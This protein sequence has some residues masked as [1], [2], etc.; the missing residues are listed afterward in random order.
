MIIPFYII[1]FIITL[2]YYKKKTY[3][4]MLMTKYFKF[5]NLTTYQA[6]SS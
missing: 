3:F 2:I 1:N 5:N 4:V 6:F